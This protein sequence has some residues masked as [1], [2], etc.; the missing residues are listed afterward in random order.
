AASFV[1]RADATP[2]SQA[3]EIQLQLGDLLFAD[4]R[5][6]D[7]LDAYRNAL[8]IA[9][10]DEQRRPRVGLISSALRVAEVDLAPQEAEKLY[11]SDPKGADAMA[12]YGD[13]LWASGLFQDA[14]NK[15]KDALSSVP[16]LARGH[17][18][19]A[20]ALAAR[21]RLDEAMNEAQ[22]ALKLSPRDL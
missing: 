2:A 19:M 11:A 9:P 20:R 1:I 22:A 8:K 10:S 12:M 4:G 13:A 14:E 15:Y 7:S 17:H 3:A 21:G 18:G 5:Y 16:D 6:V